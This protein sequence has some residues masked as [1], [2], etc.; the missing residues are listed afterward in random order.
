MN[1]YILTFIVTALFDVL[2]RYISL[3][4]LLDYDFVRYLEP[5][6]KQHTLL[7]AA[8]LAGFV[9]ATA[10]YLIHHVMT[11]QPTLAFMGVTFVISALY[12]FLMKATGLFPHLDRLRASV[13][14]LC[15]GLAFGGGCKEVF[16]V[17]PRHGFRN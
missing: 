14:I 11:P 8:L 10:Q 2:L 12:G 13:W 4:Q 7:S 17:R 15:P 6:F 3:N 1:I 9:G 5:Y 16:Q